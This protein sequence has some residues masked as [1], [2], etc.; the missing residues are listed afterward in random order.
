M[1]CAKGELGLAN[2]YLVKVKPD[3]I[4]NSGITYP[5]PTSAQEQK[6]QSLRERVQ[7]RTVVTHG[8]IQNVQKTVEVAQAQY[9]AEIVDAPVLSRR[10]MSNP[11]TRVVHHPVPV[12]QVMT[13]QRH[14]PVPHVMTEGVVRL[15]PVQVVQQ[16]RCAHPAA[17]RADSGRSSSK[18]RSFKWSG[19]LSR[20]TR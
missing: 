4:M 7:Q 16:I 19:G 18:Y 10:Q 9:I 17:I 13:Q 3:C 15:M 1:G 5:D 6:I 2:E 8:Q 14:V 12:P 20:C 11:T